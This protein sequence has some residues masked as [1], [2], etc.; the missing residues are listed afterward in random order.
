[1][2]TDNPRETPFARITGRSPITIPWMSQRRIPADSEDTVHRDISLDSF[3][4]YTR[5]IWGIT[6]NVVRMAARYPINE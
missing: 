4:L 3:N 2:R 6:E 1:M 5:M